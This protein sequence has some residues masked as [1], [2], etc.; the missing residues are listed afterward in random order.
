M[1]CQNMH[2]VVIRAHAAVVFCLTLLWAMPSG[3]QQAGSSPLP[4]ISVPL[5]AE[6]EQILARARDILKQAGVDDAEREVRLLALKGVMTGIVIRPDDDDPDVRNPKHWTLVDDAFVVALNSTPV[7]AITDL[8]V[9]HENDGVPTPRIRCYKY[10]SLV[11]I[12]AYIQYFRQTGNAAGLIAINRLI[13]HRSIPQGLPN[14]GDGLLWTRRMGSENLL[15][16]DQVWFDNPYYDR[17]QKLIYKEKYEQAINEGQSPAEAT[18]TAKVIT[19]SLIA[20]EEGTN[21]F[22][23]GDGKIIRSIS[24]LSRLSRRAFRQNAAEA[25]AH[26]QIFTRKILTIVRLQEHMLDDDYTAQACL[27]AD[28]ASVHLESFKIAQVRSPISPESLLRSYRAAPPDKSWDKLLGE[29]A[30]RNK[31]PRLMMV[32]AATIPIF[33]NDYDWSE[34]RRVRAAIETVMRRKDNAAWWRL[35]E[36]TGDDRYV[37]TARHGAVARNFTVGELC[38]SI[39]DLRLCLAF[40]AHLPTVPG[41][42]PPSFRP[43]QEYWLH[44]AE[45]ARQRV[46]LYAMQAALCERAL[47]Q[48]KTVKSTLPGSD[49]LSHFYTADEKARFAEAVK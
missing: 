30:S 24:S 10:T 36:A 44:E 8:W 42:L 14:C 38:S 13:G 6:H 26:E 23:L 48:W 47:E 35:R 20:S 49:G 31:P 27:R 40:Q 16:G 32:G 2:T 12:N 39:V 9:V 11:I 3:A 5:S 19:A 41:K 33:A 1:R 18:A 25:A 34:Q 46:P 28:P 15:P 7:E 37:L 29:M 45:W 43:E 17:G 22:Y 21:V 4:G